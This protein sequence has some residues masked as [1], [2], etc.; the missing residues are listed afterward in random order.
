MNRAAIDTNVL[1]TIIDSRDKWHPKA[2][3]LIEKLSTDKELQLVYFDCVLNETV[4]VLARRLEEQKRT[5]N[6]STLLDD[7]QTHIPV[8]MITW[9]SSDIKAVYKKV[10]ALVQQTSGTLNFHDAL[11]ALKCRDLKINSILRFDRDFDQ[12]DWLRRIA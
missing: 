2:T 1:V 10:I 5:Q 11:I 3:K 9:I 7:L 8:D 12:I 4:S 6:F